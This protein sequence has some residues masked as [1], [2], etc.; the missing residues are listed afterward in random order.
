[1]G[2]VRMLRLGF[3][4]QMPSAGNTDHFTAMVNAGLLCPDTLTIT[5]T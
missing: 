2:A 1:M 3:I 4:T 5:G